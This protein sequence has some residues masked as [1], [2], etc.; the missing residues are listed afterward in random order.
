MKDFFALLAAAGVLGLASLSARQAEQSLP[1]FRA[2]ANLV[3]VDAYA[4]LEGRAVTDLTA[5]DFEVLEDDVAQKV[6]M[7]QV[8]HARG[9]EAAVTA[10]SPSSTTEIR[11]AVQNPEA[12][13]FVIYLDMWHVSVEGSKHAVAPISSFLNNIIGPGDLVGL[14]TPEMTP[15]NLTLTRRGQGVEALVNDNW[16]WGQRDRVVTPD[17]RE[18][19]YAL[20]YPDRSATAGVAKEMIERRREEKTLRSVSDLVAYLDGLRD[21]RKFVIILS[22]GWLLFGRNDR[23]GGMLAGGQ[24]PGGPPVKVGTDGRLTTDQ[25]ETDGNLA[26]CER[27]RVMLAYIDHRIEVRQLAQR[28]NRANVTFYPIDPRGLAPFDDSIGPL[29]PATP[30]ADAQRLGAR[31]TAL[32]ELAEQTDGAWV[33]NTNQVADATA[34]LLADTSS[35]YLLSYYSTNTRLDGRFRRIS[36]RVKREGVEVRARPGYLAPNESDTRKAG[37]TTAAASRPGGRPL[38]S[39]AV[40]RA[41]ETITP[42]R[43]NQ[44]VRVQASGVAG[45]VRAVVELEMATARRPEWATGGT[46]QVTF[47]TERGAQPRVIAQTIAPGQRS[48]TLEGP[49]GGLAPGRYI[50]RAEL[51]PAKGAGPLR[52]STDA[53]VPPPGVVLGTSAIALRRGPTTGLAYQATADPRFRRTERI[54]IEVPVFGDQTIAPVARVMTRESQPLQLQ[55]TVSERTHEA[56]GQRFIV[57]DAV[58][59]PLAPADYIFE[60]ALGDKSTSY[61][62]RVVP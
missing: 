53:T 58:L 39:A 41:L 48:F 43:A 50:V 51:R 49:D 20:C 24:V 61:G 55:V 14:M 36:V 32:R 17:E 42:G 18:A 10:S 27:D 31:Q 3:R 4:S 2:G 22:E 1:R 30:A 23:L 54:R 44:P 59:A 6:E 46:L 29:R 33:L 62:F 11:D 38:P 28:A 7:F 13:V 56:S 45:N 5:Q 16:A 47:E 34:R 15:Q 26:V 8:V 12:R 52:A 57:A 40:A 9:A 37:I 35:Y 21:E 25:D 19:Q 60:V